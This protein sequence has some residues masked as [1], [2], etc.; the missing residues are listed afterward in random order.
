VKVNLI[1]KVDQEKLSEQLQ[2]LPCGMEKKLSI[3][4]EVAKIPWVIEELHS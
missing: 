2:I 3:A 4:L 1:R